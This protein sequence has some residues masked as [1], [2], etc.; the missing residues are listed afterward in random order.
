MRT[1]HLGPVFLLG[2]LVLAVGCA[3]SQAPRELVDARAEYTKASVGDAAQL[4][5]AAVHAAQ[6]PLDTAGRAFNDDATPP[7]TIDKAYGWPRKSQVAEVLA[8]SQRAK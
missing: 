7:L 1:I 6:L 8:E 2:V 5:P 4:S 3:S